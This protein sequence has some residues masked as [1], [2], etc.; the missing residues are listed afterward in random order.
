MVTLQKNNSKKL[1]FWKKSKYYKKYRKKVWYARKFFFR[2]MR[3]K[4]YRRKNKRNLMHVV[5]RRKI[6]YPF[7]L[8]KIIY[9][10]A[11]FK[12]QL[13][14]V[15]RSRVDSLR[16]KRFVFQ[17]NKRKKRKRV[18]RAVIRKHF[19]RFFIRFYRKTFKFKSVFKFLFSYY[20]TFGFKRLYS[21]LIKYSRLK[22]NLR[23]KKRKYIE[24]N[25]KNLVRSTRWPKMNLLRQLHYLMSIMVSSGRGALAKKFYLK[26]LL[27]LK[28]KYKKEYLK[29]Y[30]L[31]LEKLRPLILYR[32]VY[33][34]GKKYKIP[35]LMPVRKSYNFA[36]K[37]LL[38]SAHSNLMTDISTALF[39]L[40]IS[41]LKNEGA[42]IKLRKEYHLSSFDNKSYIYLL[43]HLKKGFA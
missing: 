43:K 22:Y 18:W 3:K 41:S 32:T 2:V 39:T 13:Y 6:T 17:F 15:T 40:I 35:I 26:L 19:K 8:K 34:G 7:A 1:L 10:K 4:M 27:L 16:I 36:T 28:F 12:K 21:Q 33:T 20:K 30:L 11:S 9:R 38:N 5:R 31:C 42:A 14:H 29:K 23:R 24:R 25:K 37:W